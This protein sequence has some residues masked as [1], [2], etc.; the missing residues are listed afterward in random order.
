MP[1][2]PEVEVVRQG[3]AK[4]VTNKKIETVS[5]LHPRAIRNF[6]GSKKNFS[7]QL[8]GEKIVAVNRRGKYM[9]LELSSGKALVTH[10]GMSG[11]VLIQKPNQE[12]EKHLRI[13]FTFSNY[14]NEMHFVDQRTF[15]GMHIDELQSVSDSEVIPNSV[16]HIAR[17]PFDP[18]FNPEIVVVNLRKKNTQIKRALL[19]QTLISGIGNIYADEALWRSKLHWAMHTQNISSKKALELLG[20]ASDV[21]KEAL[22]EGGTSFDSLYVDVNGQSGYFERGLSA[23]GRED[24]PCY[25]CGRQMVRDSFMNRSSFRCPKCQPTPRTSQ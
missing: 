14:K 16:A 2:L 19:D 15:G 23:Y 3:L 21:M 6:P 7:S 8:T 9:W 4:W 10:L 17:D 22:A 20:H 11:Q 12:P 5:V 13:R 25:R 1:E 24:E 18:N